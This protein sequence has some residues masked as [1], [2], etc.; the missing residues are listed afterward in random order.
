MAMLAAPDRAGVWNN[1]QRPLSAA[2][3]K[4]VPSSFVI[5]TTRNVAHDCE[6]RI[7]AGFGPP[8]YLGPH[9]ASIVLK[10]VAQGLLIVWLT[11]TFTF[12][13]IHAAP[14]EP[15]SGY[16]DDPR[17]TAEMREALRAR[18]GLDR[19]V[20]QQYV[21]FLQSISSGDLGESSLIAGLSSLRYSP[22]RYRERCC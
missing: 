5:V 13:L 8:P 22:M 11:T 17:A 4:A 16:S 20:A 7:V 1:R 21:R 18:Y 12:F 19:P 3:A 2:P 15:F 14:G 10:R 6:P 9:M